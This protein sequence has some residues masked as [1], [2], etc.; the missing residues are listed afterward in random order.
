[1]EKLL[2]WVGPPDSD[3]EEDGDDDDIDRF[4]DDMIMSKFGMSAFEFRT[5]DG[6][7]YTDDRCYQGSYEDAMNAIDFCPDADDLRFW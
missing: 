4:D 6:S 5:L 3:A 1:M 2:R 7:R